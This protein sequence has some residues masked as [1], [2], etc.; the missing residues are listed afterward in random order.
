MNCALAVSTGSVY[1]ASNP[2]KVAQMDPALM[3]PRIDTDM[4]HPRYSERDESNLHR[5]IAQ[6]V[7]VAAVLDD[8]SC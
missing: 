2:S 3:G 1:P 5:S 8:L 7:A 6:A 4:V